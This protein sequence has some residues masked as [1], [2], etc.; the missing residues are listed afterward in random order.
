M[1]NPVEPKE[2]MVRIAGCDFPM[3]VVRDYDAFELLE[4]KLTTRPGTYSKMYV[5]YEEFWKYRDAHDQDIK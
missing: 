5:T 3:R 2:E 4:L 1:A